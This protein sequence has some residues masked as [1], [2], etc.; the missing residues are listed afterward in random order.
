MRDEE[1]REYYRT[2][3]VCHS[4]LCWLFEKNI[5]EPQVRNLVKTFREEMHRVENALD[6]NEK[7]RELEESEK[8]CFNV[9]TIKTLDDRALKYY[10]KSIT[11]FHQE[12]LHFDKGYCGDPK[13]IFHEHFKELEKILSDEIKRR[14]EYYKETGVLPKE[15]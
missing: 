9:E 11:Q 3:V 2:L 7:E 1:L 12:C 13:R 10:R 8:L 14:E 6:K 5:T 15:V 4:E